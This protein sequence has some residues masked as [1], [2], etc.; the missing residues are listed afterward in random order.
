MP[1]KRLLEGRW[2]SLSGNQSEALSDLIRIETVLKDADPVAATWTAAFCA[3]HGQFTM[4][5]S[6]ANA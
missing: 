5:M 1:E 2:L 6:E 3:L 4:T